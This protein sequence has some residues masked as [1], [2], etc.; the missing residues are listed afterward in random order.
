MCPA[1]SVVAHITLA[2]GL[3][4]TE[5]NHLVSLD[6]EVLAEVY[7]HWIMP[8]RIFPPLL[9]TRLLSDLE[10]FLACRGDGSGVQ[11]V[12]W[13]HRQFWEAAEVWVFPPTDKD[14]DAPAM[15]AGGS[16]AGRLK[17]FVNSCLIPRRYEH[18]A[19]AEY[20][21][22]MWAGR[23]KPYS[24]ALKGKCA[25]EAC[26][27]RKVPQQPIL[28]DGRIFEDVSSANAMLKLNTR[29]LSRLVHHLIESSQQDPVVRELTSPE[30]IAAK[31]AMRD[32]AVLMREY[33][34]A[35]K[36]FPGAADD[37]GKCMA[38]VGS[39]LKYLQEQPQLFALQMCCQLP[40]QHPLCVASKYV[41]NSQKAAP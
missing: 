32:G 9:V 29:R 16:S 13:M 31:F 36:R 27:D 35:I 20:F 12:G 10:D 2:E 18:R 4:E 25:G 17:H 11:L 38:T 14:R 39:N 22:G 24:D 40:D 6:D 34:R 21:C 28:L 19:L 41:T 1:S 37:L 8:T 3:S 15:Y 26:A 23:P 30:Y 5:I 7:E 33:S